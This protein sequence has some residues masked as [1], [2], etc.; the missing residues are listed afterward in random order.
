MTVWD[1]FVFWIGRMLAETIVGIAL[2]IGVM[3]L[4]SWVSKK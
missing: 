2:I 4:V 3:V 1:G